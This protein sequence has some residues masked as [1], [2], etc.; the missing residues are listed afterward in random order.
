MVLISG[1]V[2]RCYKGGGAATKLYTLVAACVCVKREGWRPS[3]RGQGRMFRSLGRNGSTSPQLPVP[4]EPWTYLPFSSSAFQLSHSRLFVNNLLRGW[5]RWFTET[6]ALAVASQAAERSDS[7]SHATKSFASRSETKKR[8]QGDQCETSAIAHSR[9]TRQEAGKVLNTDVYH[10][11][12]ANSAP[13]RAQRCPGDGNHDFE[14]H[15]LTC[16]R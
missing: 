5:E 6:Q 1:N 13:S 11:A 10:I 15:P 3:Q 2:V 7:P 4:V 9:E 14:H 8:R 12:R 16:Q